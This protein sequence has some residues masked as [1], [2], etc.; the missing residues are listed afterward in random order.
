MKQIT[1]IHTEYLVY[2]AFRLLVF[3]VLDFDDFASGGC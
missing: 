1:C 2:E 3:L